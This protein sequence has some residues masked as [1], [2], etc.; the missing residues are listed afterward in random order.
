MRNHSWMDRAEYIDFGGWYMLPYFFADRLAWIAFAGILAAF[1]GTCL[2]ISFGLFYWI[3][4]RI[5]ELLRP[6]CL[7][8]IFHSFT[9]RCLSLTLGCVSWIQQMN[10]PCFC[11]HSVS[12]CLF[13]VNLD[14]WHWELPMSS[15]GCFLIFCYCV[16]LQ[17]VCL[18]LFIFSV[19]GCACG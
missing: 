18:G 12:L 16:L 11:I 17:F 8:Y 4:K 10:G 1:V 19:L 9:L 3:L 13:V 7:E 5:H 2:L 14:H 15:V 6:I